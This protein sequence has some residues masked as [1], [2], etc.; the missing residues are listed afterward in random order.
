[1]PLGECKANVHSEE[2]E[3]GR[4]FI[5]CTSQNSTGADSQG[6]VSLKKEDE[7][8]VLGKLIHV[9]IV[10]TFYHLFVGTHS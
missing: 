9:H 10:K 1:M 7:V 3:E 6:S 8:L 2:V 4:K 5:T